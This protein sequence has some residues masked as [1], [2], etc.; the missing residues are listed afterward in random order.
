MD[1]IEKKA[2]SGN[3]KEAYELLLHQN[4]TTEYYEKLLI[5]TWYLRNNNLS[6]KTY[7]ECSNTT[8]NNIQHTYNNFTFYLEDLSFFEL[9]PKIICIYC[10]QSTFLWDSDTKS[11]NGSEEAIVYLSNE[12]INLGYKVIIFSNPPENSKYRL[13]FSNPFYVKHHE[14]NDY[15]TKYNKTKKLFDIILIWRQTS[16]THISKYGKKTFIWLHDIIENNTFSHDS[17]NNLTGILW[18]T[19]YHYNNGVEKNFLLK[20]T[21][22]DH[23]TKSLIFGNG[24][25]PSQFQKNI[26][27]KKKLCIYASN[28]VRGLEQLLVIWNDVVKEI[29]EA[30]L[31]IYYGWNTWM[32]GEHIDNILNKIKGLLQNLPNVEE[33]GSVDHYTLAEKF[34]QSEYWL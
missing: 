31:K 18:L 7:N 33:C 2:Q 1:V 9:Y 11:L 22:Y 17:V 27:K 14:F 23:P 20:Y 8:F 21:G 29:P 34:L 16:V 5:Y 25:V 24:I 30:E 28:Y 13:P 15:V 3:Y 6:L 32:Y 26:K 19:R 12:L 4:K 10:Y